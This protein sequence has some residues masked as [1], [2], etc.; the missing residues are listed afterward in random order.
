ML[1]GKAVSPG[2]AVGRV[3]VYRP[4]SEGVHSVPILES[5]AD[6]SVRRFMTSLDTVKSDLESAMKDMD[7][8]NA[9]IFTAHKLVVEDSELIGA[10][11]GKI[12]NELCEPDSAV[13]SVI[14]DFCTIL[15][16]TPDAT[17]ASRSTDLRDVKRSILRALHGVSDTS[18]SSLPEGTVIVAADLMP[19]DTVHLDREHTACIITEMGGETSHTAIIA[20]KLGIPAVLGVENATAAL[21]DGVEVAVDAVRG[22]IF[23]EPDEET[24]KRNLSSAETFRQRLLND[25]GYKYIR[26]LLSDGHKI[27]IGA[28]VGEDFGTADIEAFDGVGLLRTEFMFMQRDA[29]PDEEEQFLEY[30]RIVEYAAGKPVVLRTLDVGGDKNLSYL[31]QSREINPFLGCRGLRFCLEN[32]E[33]FLTQ[34]RAALRASA[35]GPLRIMF[36]MVSGVDDIESALECVEEAKLEL[37]GRGERYD[38]RIK[39]GVMIEVPSAAVMADVIAK[40]VDFASI[41]TNDLCQ[42]LFAADR[43]NHRVER[44]F[45][46]FSP[47]LFRAISGVCRAFR[48]QGKPV[49]VCGELAGDTRATEVLVGLGVT[50]LSMR[51]NAV[52]SVKKRLSEFSLG[53]ATQ[54]AKRILAMSEEKEVLEFIEARQA[55]ANRVL[56]PVLGVR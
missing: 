41:G 13:D 45:K 35:L 38:E 29:L 17:I 2:Y 12:K 26:P 11:V 33:I 43:Q 53:R 4:Q 46:S 44:Y 52:G 27:L 54:S 37:K 23:P 30:G 56:P 8:D 5:D 40:R 3:L 19:S 55:H 49:T 51:E 31:P 24:V 22:E 47:A 32:R 15:E 25:E 1:K 50:G 9:A 20:R 39:L 28:N 48:R 14:E 16:R 7:D 42:F 10:V 36:P 34:L 18:L 6:E 21:R